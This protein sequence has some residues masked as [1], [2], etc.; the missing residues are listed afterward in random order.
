MR[1]EKLKEK[2]RESVTAVLPITI[3]VLLLGVFAVPMETGTT[4]L[5]LTGAVLLIIG[6]GFFQ[7]GAETA[8]TPLGEGIG[9]QLWGNKK[10]PAILFI[11]FLMGVVITIAEP[12]L[13]VLANQVESIPNMTLI[14]TVAV[15][16]GIFLAIAV[17]RILFQISLSKIL[18]VL[19]LVLFLISFLA[20]SE[21]VAVAFDA[22][23]VTTGPMTVPFIMALGVGL[24]AARSDKDGSSDSFGLVSLCSVGPILMVML[25]G[26]FYNPSEAAYSM[27]EIPQVVTLQDVAREFA[28]EFPHYAREVF[29]S[30]FPILAVFLVFQ[31]LTRRYHRRQILKMIIGFVYTIIGLILFLTGVNVGFAPVGNLLGSD[32]A[33]GPS[34]WLLIPIG[35]VIG[36]YIVKAEPAVQ[37]LNHQVES[38][39]NGT[40][41]AKAMNNCLSFG[42]AA[43]VALAMVRVITGLNIYW[44]LIPGYAL[45]LIM[46][47][48]VPPIFV[49]IAFDSGGVASGPM[50]SC[51]LLPLAMGACIS[52]GGNVVTDAFGIVALVALAPLIAIQIM[53]LIYTRK[54]KKLQPA[55]AT[56]AADQ[57]DEIVEWEEE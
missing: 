39:T 40:I 48:L 33:S 32:L 25:L 13:Q 2:T 46:S 37:L 34:K 49:G 38:I 30:V 24:G 36:Y 54:L 31:L 47:R 16:V 29:L 28:R 1:N 6:M 41:S 21:F 8:M 19:Y 10:I 15:G 52:A 27:V 56:A 18:C 57:E 51:F 3:L 35:M 17:L 14:W 23:G 4:A 26:I 9:A 53:G 11:C 20:P 12:D 50:T 43:A 44:I 22:G 5:F 55:Q 42:V 45:A 7:L